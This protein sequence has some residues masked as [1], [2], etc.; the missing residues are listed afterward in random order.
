MKLK[1]GIS[2]YSVPDRSIDTLGDFVQ[3]NDFDAIELWD[4]P[5]PKRNA[6]SHKYL[7]SG[8]RDLSVHAPLLNLGD[9][10]LFRSNVQGLRK[11]IERAGAYGARN[12]V[13][14]T[15]ILAGPDVS[16]G[17][18]LAKKVVD[19]NLDSLD[20]CDIMLCLENV[21]YLGDDLISDFEQL[22]ALVDC[23]PSHMVGVV[24]DVSHA[25]ITGG[26]ESGIEVLRDRIE[27][28]HLSDNL[29]ERKV[30]HMPIGEGNI[31]FRHLERCPSLDDHAG[32]LEITPGSNWQKSLLDSRR[33]LQE[34]DL[35]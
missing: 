20:E 14:H 23:F 25:N 7:E 17:V 21:G 31:D 6:K 28:V 13:L 18:D 3:E 24:F 9:E 26:V 1:L 2:I 32:I 15:G 5:L 34:L 11:T 33:V 29:G 8:D 12:V 22:A 19:S 10:G 27:Y 30:H 35:A 16:G 4:S